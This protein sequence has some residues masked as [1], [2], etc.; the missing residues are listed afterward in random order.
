M[1]SKVLLAVAAVFMTV[2]AIGYSFG[3]IRPIEAG[4]SPAPGYWRL[5]LRLNL[6][7]AN[8][9]LYLAAAVAWIAVVLAD[10]ARALPWLVGVAATS[11]LYS[12]VTV[13]GFTR[14]DF[15]HAIPRALALAAYAA[16]FAVG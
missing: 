15:A 7:L 1:T 13:V 2:D 9:A 8:H 16:A 12:V 4:L 3:A 10:D 14:R 5:R 6:L 11:A